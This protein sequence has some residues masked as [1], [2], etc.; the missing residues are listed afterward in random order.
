[1]GFEYDMTE[2]VPDT[3]GFSLLQPG[4][5]KVQLN[6]VLDEQ[7][8]NDGNGKYHKFQYVVIEGDGEGTYI[9]DKYFT[10]GSE[11]A[12]KRSQGRFSS[13]AHAIDKPAGHTD[14]ML[15]IPFVAKVGI[16]KN[17]DPKYKDSNNILSFHP[18]DYQRPPAAATA[19]PAPLRQTPNVAAQT[20]PAAVGQS[21]AARPWA[22][23]A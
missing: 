13:L 1:M 20:R 5:Y 6:D 11:G 10:L 2:V 16:E 17:S 18:I 21:G 19:A 8:T 4:F 3:G 22:K 15:H 14:M 9:W 12:L 23:R 7:A